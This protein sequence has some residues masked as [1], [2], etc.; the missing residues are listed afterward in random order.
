M[1][2]EPAAYGSGSD[3]VGVTQ[4][5]RDEQDEW[6]EDAYDSME[7]ENALQKKLV[8]LWKVVVM[9]SEPGVLGWM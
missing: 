9:G 6:A 7:A 2:E 3:G 5:I 1:R 8:E 4:G